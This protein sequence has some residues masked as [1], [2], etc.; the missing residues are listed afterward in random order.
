MTSGP[1]IVTHFRNYVPATDIAPTVA[2][3][4]RHVPEKYLGGLT[5]IELTNATSTRKLRRGK[6]WS[7]SKKVR[8]SKCL[9]FYCGDHIQLLVDNLL[10][11]YPTWALRWPMFRSVLIG[12]VLYHEIG[13]HIHATQ[14]PVYKERED[15][16]DQ[17]SKY[18]LKLFMRQHYWYMMPIRRPLAYMFKSYCA[19]RYPD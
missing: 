2:L 6:T 15:V 18:L 12:Q 8:M 14:I 1:H 13:H 4:L 5:Y 16:A 17:W 19:W 9:G 7:R 10:G 3:L 11:S